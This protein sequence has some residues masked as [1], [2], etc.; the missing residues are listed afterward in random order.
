MK[1]S[2]IWLHHGAF[3]LYILIPILQLTGFHPLTAIVSTV[4]LN[5]INIPLI[6]YLNG[7]L[8]GRKTGLI[9][10]LIFAFYYQCILLARTGYHISLIPL[11]FLVFALCLV[12]K[13]YFLSG[14]FLAF[15]Y[16]V[17]ILAVI[18]WPLAF[19][20]LFFKKEPFLNFIIGSFLGLIPFL[21]S[22][23]IQTFGVVFWLIKNLT[24]IFKFSGVSN[25][26]TFVIYIP[27]IMVISVLLS[28]LNR[29]VLYVAGIIYFIVNLNILLSNHY[30]PPDI[31]YGPDYSQKMLISRQILADSK[32]AIPEVQ[33]VGGLP[34]DTNY[35]DSYIYLIRWLQ[36]KG[37]KPAGIYSKFIVDENTLNIR[38]LE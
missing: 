3:W 2:I 10:A 14:L 38:M 16:Q 35:S 37:V 13:R 22:G 27:L 1:S 31:F 4:V 17:H 20:Y 15:L 8:F 32:T 33:V 28:R 23:P 5:L 19:V 11:L 6:Y 34:G 7:I 30:Y 9:S 21:I 25:S 18:Y 12:K 29:K 26:Q 36:K 24:V